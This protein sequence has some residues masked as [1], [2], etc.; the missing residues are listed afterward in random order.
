MSVTLSVHARFL[1]L[2]SCSA[3][4]V[5]PHAAGCCLEPAALRRSPWPGL[6]GAETTEELLSVSLDALLLAACFIPDGSGGVKI[7]LLL[8]E[9]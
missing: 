7:L 1:Q 6:E 9:H 5:A 8:T 3:V 4:P 2:Q